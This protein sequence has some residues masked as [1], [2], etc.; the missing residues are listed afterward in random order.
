[1]PY[2]RPTL[3]QLR[4]QAVQ[5]INAAR[6]SDASGNLVVGLLQKAVLRVMAYV[7]AGMGYLHYG[8]LDWIAK[9]SVPW[10]ATDEFLLA[11]AALKGITPQPA[12]AA[13][14]TLSFGGTVNAAIPAGTGFLRSDG[15]A[16]TA[17]AAATVGG[18]GLAT[19][20]AIAVVAGAN[21][22]C[23]AGTVFALASS[24]YQ[25]QNQGSALTAFAGGADQETTDSLRTR[26]LQAY[27]APPQGGDRQ[28]YIGWALAVAGVTRAWVNPN[29][30]GPGTV[31]LYVM[32]DA[33]EAAHGGF[34]QG[35]NGGA[36]TE[37]RT[38]PATGDQAA[39]AD[40][41]F[42]LQPVTAL[43]TVYA[44][45]AQPVTFAVGNLGANNTAAMQT[46]IT[47]AL[48]DMFVRVANVGNSVDPA[49]GAAWPAIDPATWYEAIGAVAGLSNFTVTVPA[50][51][52]VASAGA[53]PVLGSIT[54]SS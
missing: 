27:A 10:T 30:G 4:D 44:P 2:A 17:T 6:I 11:W 7:Q 18:N 25:V 38:T 21:G 15:A 41:I 42:A 12:V 53:L 1:M 47:A 34:P 9:Q 28:D 36:F 40:A 22:N 16:F 46:A 23:D 49:S 50:A 48:T 19:I 3:T 8:F 35:S 43:V 26:M 5:D 52:I 54:F 13:S 33:T 32:F 31:W 37:P 39:V 24:I 45:V 51:P 20:A 14:G 29:G